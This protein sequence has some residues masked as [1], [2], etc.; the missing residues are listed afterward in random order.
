MSDVALWSMLDLAKMVHI[1]AEVNVE[2]TC[3][4][5]LFNCALQ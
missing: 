4:A 5:F 2:S 1:R 3:P